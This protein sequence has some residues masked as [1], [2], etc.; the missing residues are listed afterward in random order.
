MSSSDLLWGLLDDSM[1]FCVFHYSLF[2][3][4]LLA[5]PSNLQGF[6][7]AFVFGYKIKKMEYMK[8]ISQ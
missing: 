3:T 6:W 2:F 4:Q 7:F 5:D 8:Y 1:F